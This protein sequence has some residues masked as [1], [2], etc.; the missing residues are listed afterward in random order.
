MPEFSSKIETNIADG[1][2]KQKEENPIQEMAADTVR[3]ING[4]GTSEASSSS[5]D[6]SFLDAML[7]REND[8][9][10]EFPALLEEPFYYY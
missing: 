10:L 8:M 6:S 1:K 4:G 7:E 3:T 9:F 5:C 2:G